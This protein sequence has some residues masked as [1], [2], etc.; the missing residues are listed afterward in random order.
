[1]R[2][3]KPLLLGAAALSAA[4]LIT[5]AQAATTPL[6]RPVTATA[7]TNAIDVHH[8]DHRRAGRYRQRADVVVGPVRT[9]IRRRVVRRHGGVRVVR[10][11]K[12]T[13]Q[14]VRYWRHGQRIVERRV[15]DRDCHF[16]RRHGHRDVHRHGNRGI[17]FNFGYY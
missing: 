17:Q 16:V 13:F 2:V 6:D 7:Q 4:F 10:V 1:M 3:V 9:E 14:N 12:V 5:P 11:C 8:R 15:L